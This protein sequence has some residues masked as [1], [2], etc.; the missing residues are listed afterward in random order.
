MPFVLETTTQGESDQK[1]F[2]F[3]L[4]AEIK[5][6]LDSIAKEKNVGVQDMGKQMI[7]SCLADLGFELEVKRFQ[8]PL[9]EKRPYGRPKKKPVSDKLK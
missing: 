6:L 1:L 7:L 8:A 4:P 2:A 5:K 3:M 9:K